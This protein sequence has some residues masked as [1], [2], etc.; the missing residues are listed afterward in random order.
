MQAPAEMRTPN[1]YLAYKNRYQR[2]LPKINSA[3]AGEPM[4]ILVA[5]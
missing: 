1:W 2:E 5:L 3:G 4:T